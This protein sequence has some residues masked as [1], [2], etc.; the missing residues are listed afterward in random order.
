[1]D[2]FKKDVVKYLN[3]KGYDVTEEEVFREGDERIFSGRDGY[4]KTIFG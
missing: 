4:E 3:Y 1:M 2:S